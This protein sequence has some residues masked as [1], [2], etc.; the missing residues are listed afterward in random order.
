[1]LIVTGDNMKKN[2]KAIGFNMQTIILSV[3]GAVLLFSMMVAL[4]PTF[5]SSISDLLGHVEG[6]TTTY[7]TGPSTVAGVI[8]DNWGYFLVAGLLGVVILAIKKFVPSS[9]M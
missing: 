4:L 5:S 6:N 7:G 1:M 3:V 8:G 2:K 9:G